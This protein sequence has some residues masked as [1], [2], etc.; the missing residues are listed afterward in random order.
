MMVSLRTGLPANY[1][2]G[3]GT[4]PSDREFSWFYV[5]M[6]G[7]KSLFRKCEQYIRGCRKE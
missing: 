5:S 1:Q 7:N 3:D 4:K 2:G 6:V